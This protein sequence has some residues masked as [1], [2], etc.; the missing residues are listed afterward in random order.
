NRAY[1]SL[2]A[3]LARFRLAPPQPCEN[4]YIVDYIARHSLKQIENEAGQIGWNWKFDPYMLVNFDFGRVTADVIGKIT[5]Q[6]AMMRGADSALVDDRIWDFMR[7][8]RPH[9]DMISIPDAQ[10]HVMLDQPLAFINALQTQLTAWS[11]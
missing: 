5:C 7:S 8:Q 1:A 4:H 9:M 11:H 10:H 3:A 6:M 2:E